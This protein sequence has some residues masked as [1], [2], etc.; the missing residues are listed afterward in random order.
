M[1]M[2]LR[3][4]RHAIK[5]Q[6]PKAIVQEQPKETEEVAKVEVKRRGPYKQAKA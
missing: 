3:R 6:A 5:K 4:H 2:M 1:G